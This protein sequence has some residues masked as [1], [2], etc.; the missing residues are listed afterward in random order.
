MRILS[1]LLDRSVAIINTV[2]IT[3]ILISIVILSSPSCNTTLETK[4]TTPSQCIT[5]IMPLS[6]EYASDWIITIHHTV[7]PS[8]N[9]L[10]RIASIDNYHKSL[11]WDEI[12]YHFLIGEDGS[13][14]V[15]RSLDKDGAH[16]K[17]KKHHNIGIAFIGDLSNTPPSKKAIKAARALIQLLAR[18]YHIPNTEI[19]FHKDLAAT[20]CPGN[21]S[22]SLILP[23]K[24]E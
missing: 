20:E 3:G 16:V 15:G 12:G 17:N 19:Y 23:D 11:G 24:S 7:T 9:P 22:K 6:E 13:I 14:W 2:I 21:W 18:C 5:C 8:N 10:D 1:F 4:Q